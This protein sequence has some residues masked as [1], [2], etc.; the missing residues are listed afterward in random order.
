MKPV[1]APINFPAWLKENGHLL[2]P[3][4]N[5]YCLYNEKDFVVMVV[6]GPNARND[7][8]V[9]TTEEWFYQY[10][11]DMLL[12]VIESG[13]TFKDIPIKEGEMFL[14]PANTPHNP[15]RYA[16]TIGIVLERVRPSDSVDKLRWYCDK[17]SRPVLIAETNLG[18]V[19]NLGTQL[20]PAI[21]QWQQTES[22]RK[23]PDCGTVAPPK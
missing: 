15:V 13:E 12:K 7:Y 23:C 21:E 6:G 3:P 8:H 11:G 20:K 1:P 22:M 14:L 4:V 10:K 17:H 5:N 2:Q 16:D 18:H 19:T 9:N